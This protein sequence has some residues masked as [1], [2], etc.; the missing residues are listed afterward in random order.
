MLRAAIE[1]PVAQTDAKLDALLLSRAS[2]LE[3]RLDRYVDAEAMASRALAA[4]RK[5]RDRATKVQSLN[6]LGTCALQ[7]GRLDDARRYFKQALEA[8]APEGQA[9]RV[10]SNA[11]PP[12]ARREGA[13]QLCGGAATVVAIACC[14]TSRLG[15]SAEEALCLNNLGALCL[16]MRED[17]A[18]GVHLRQGLAICERD[19]I[20]GTRGYILS[21]LTELAMRTGDL[22]AAESHAGRAIEVATASGQ[23][24]G[25]V[26]GKDESRS[27]GRATRR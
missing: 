5:S 10:G 18:A 3:Y 17:D 12:G 6:V 14:S 21:N 13:R 22:A 24:R 27:P 4:T 25:P 19:G 8:A 11:R 26:L 16:T 20:V 23:P 9:Q 2:H 1:S 15:D 7:L